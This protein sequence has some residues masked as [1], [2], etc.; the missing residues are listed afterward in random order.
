[1]NYL[2]RKQGKS[3]VAHLWNDRDTYCRMASTGGLNLKKYKIINYLNGYRIC[4][5]CNAVKERK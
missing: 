3:K 1:M 4:T 2:I 5:M